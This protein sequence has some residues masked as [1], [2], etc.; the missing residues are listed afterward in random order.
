MQAKLIDYFMWVKT[1]AKGDKMLRAKLRHVV[2]TFSISCILQSFLQT[3]FC[4]PQMLY[5]FRVSKWSTK[6][7]CAHNSKVLRCKDKLSQPGVKQRSQGEKHHGK[8]VE[9]SSPLVLLQ[10]M[11]LFMCLAITALLFPQS[12]SQANEGLFFIFCSFFV[13]SACRKFLPKQFVQCL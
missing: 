6:Q 13:Q 7:Y 2:P 3:C 4:L 5:F 10:Y 8:T 9:K 12:S 1:L 11:V